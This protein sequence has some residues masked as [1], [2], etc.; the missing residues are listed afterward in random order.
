MK[1]I[2]YVFLIL[3]LTVSC[4]E[5]PEEVEDNSADEALAQTLEPNGGRMVTLTPEAMNVVSGWLAFVTAQNEVRDLRNATGHQIISNA[6]PLRQIMNSLSSTLPDTLK[7]T[8]VESRVTVLVTKAEVLHQQSIKKN[9]TA[10]EIFGAATSLIN[11]FEN[12]K[13][14]L[15]ERFLPPP[16]D[17]QQELERQFNVNADSLPA[18]P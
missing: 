7:V 13:L 4:K 18:E 17:F 15:N 6:D 1:N 9:K 5:A 10:S 8:P 16:G 11:E 12:F 14:Q 2:Y 3:I